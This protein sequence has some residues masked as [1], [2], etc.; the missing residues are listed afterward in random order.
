[1]DLHPDSARLDAIGTTTEVA[2]LFE[3]TPQAVSQWRKTGIPK[4]R[5]QTMKLMRPNLFL[6]EPSTDFQPAQPPVAEQAVQR[7]AQL[8][9]AQA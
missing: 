6:D 8:A 3:V 2:S 7:S 4:A 5:R 9:K 1:M